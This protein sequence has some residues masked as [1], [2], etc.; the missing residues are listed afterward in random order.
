MTPVVLVTILV[1]LVLAGL[2]GFIGLRLSTG[3]GSGAPTVMAIFLLAITF[4][5]VAIFSVTFIRKTV[6][7]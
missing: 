6:G 2:A 3:R 7:G 5:I 4:S 1:A